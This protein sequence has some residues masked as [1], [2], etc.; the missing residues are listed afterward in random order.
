MVLAVTDDANATDESTDDP[1]QDDS[2]RELS[3][4]RQGKRP[5]SKAEWGAWMPR[6]PTNL[7]PMAVAALAD[8]L[9][10]KGI[11]PS[12]MISELREELAESGLG[13]RSWRAEEA[14]I[15]RL[16]LELCHGPPRD[17]CV[18]CRRAPR[19]AS[20]I[21]C[22]H[23]VLC[24]PCEQQVQQHIKA[25]PG[26]SEVK[27]CRLLCPYCRGFEMEADPK[28]DSLFRTID[29]NSSGTIEPAELL[30]HSVVAGQTP[31]S[32]AD[33]FLALDVN[34]DGLLS[35]EEWEA[36]FED[37]LALS[38]Q[39]AAQALTGGRAAAL[40]GVHLECTPGVAE[41][42]FACV[43]VTPH[44]AGGATSDST[45]GRGNGTD[46]STAAEA[47]TDNGA[48]MQ[49]SL[50]LSLVGRGGMFQEARLSV[51]PT[52][53]AVHAPS[54]VETASGETQAD[55]LP[56]SKA[57]PEVEVEEALVLALEVPSAQL[58][59]QLQVPTS[60]RSIVL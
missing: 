10:A 14:A 59:V 5:W 42:N 43:P 39:G 27:L 56:A 12:V 49:L 51:E 53:R 45:A 38:Q 9:A 7:P 31:E 15:T 36:G 8:A 55:A 17:V 32:V 40:G 22:G 60:P 58:S 19:E 28:P 24:A 20:M 18:K 52:P 2:P 25:R 54:G 35:P 46:A 57:N 34:G 37:F 21:G 50:E 3:E 23:T 41:D 44:T 11:P 33:L 13:E 16:E 47:G 4:A 29:T 1:T 30:I 26:M 6:S 48:A